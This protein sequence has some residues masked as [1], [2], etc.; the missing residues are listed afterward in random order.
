[1]IEGNV[2]FA[3]VG[4]GRIGRRHAT[5]VVK[6]QAAQLVALSDIDTSVHNELKEEFG[7]PVYTTHKEMFANH[8]EIHVV[9]ICSPNGEHAQQSIDALDH[10]FNVVCE[11]PMALTKVDAESVMFHALKRNR[12]VFCVMQNR[13]SPPAKW[14]KE[15]VES[16]VLGK[17][18]LVQ[19]NCYWNRDND[20][21]KGGDPS[22]WKGKLASDGGTLF[23]QF[24]HFID[25]MFWLFGD[26]KNIDAKFYDF[27]HQ[28]T[29]EFE[30]SGIV[31]FDFVK[32]GAGSLNYST[33]VWNS[34][35]ESSITIIGEK[36]S[37]KVGGQYMNEVEVCNIDGYTM[38]TLEETL[39]PNDYGKYKGSAANHHFVIENVVETLKGRNFV[40][41]NSLE[42]LK[43]VEIIENIYKLKNQL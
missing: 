32:E 4:A 29:T 1:M 31:H 30:D 3:V 34:N 22:Y 39:P 41:T 2:N 10:N 8:P 19:I 23:T 26:I 36:G 28:E 16:R 35:L 27:N 5:M 9:N 7:V 25:T 15:V 6:H 38:P 17:I 43:V 37:I 14:L 40:N 20:Y 33:S 24:S 21:Y 13:Y 11:K 12:L 42:G 18:F